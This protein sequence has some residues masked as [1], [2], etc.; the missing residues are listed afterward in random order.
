MWTYVSD[1]ASVSPVSAGR[2]VFLQGS[3]QT[4][5]ALDSFDGKEAFSIDINA[6]ITTGMAICNG[7]I[8]FGT[9]TG[10]V[11]IFSSAKYDFQIE[12]K[13]SIQIGSPGESVKF[14]VIVKA[15]E[16][17]PDTITFAVQGF[18]CSC[19]GVTRYFDETTIVTPKNVN[20]TIDI[21]AEAEEAR[22]NISVLAY[23][24]KDLRREVDGVLEIKGQ[25]NSTSLD[26]VK[27]SGP[28]RSGSEFI[29]DIDIKEA[30]NVRS[31]SFMISYPK[32]LLYVQDAT[33]GTFFKGEN[34]NQMFDK[35]IQNDK[36]FT[37][38]GYSRKDLGD[39]GSGNITRIIF[40]A[41]KAGEAKISFSKYSVRD[42][43]LWETMIKPNNL[44]LT[45][46]PGTQK[47]IILTIGKKEIEVN[48]QKYPSDV[49]PILET[50]R[51]L[52]PLRI[53]ADNLDSTI[54]WEAKEQKI[55]ILHYSKRI[56]LW[57]NRVTCFV[58]GLEKNMPSNVPPR[59]I[60]NRTYVPLLFI[61][62]ELDASVTWNAK[63]QQITI[64]YPAN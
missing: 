30:M 1:H 20:L 21:G 36:G 58:D 19:K 38:I 45:V 49:A 4:F 40:K 27:P 33:K 55:T 61:A 52:V 59:L 54:N 29:M 6:N 63:T 44:D 23:S 24:A 8:I 3:K 60:N 13:P 39:S 34:S 57:I 43:F 32:D 5:V 2:L 42:T 26:M 62:N 41:L 17:F 28:V 47:K 50:G 37:V 56:E 35:L 25:K 53:V 51:T 46:L 22:Y 12:L 7:K 10:K 14:E 31:V 64:L 16:G 9:D 11:L 18:P 48:G 15:T